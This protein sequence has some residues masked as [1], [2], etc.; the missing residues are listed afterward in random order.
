MPPYSTR[1]SPPMNNN[2][3]I[4]RSARQARRAL[5]HAEQS[6]HAAQACQHARHSTPFIAAQRIAAY[7]A[8]DG[9]LDPLPLVNH[10]IECNKEIYLPVLQPTTQNQ[11]WF[12]R[13]IPGEP[14]I[15]NRYAI[16]EPD[17]K[18]HPPIKAWSLDLVLLPLVAFDK[19][20][21]RVG[22]GGGYYDRTFAFM[23]KITAMPRPKLF[24]YAHDCQMTA[25]IF[26]NKWDVPLDGVITEKQ[27]Y[28]S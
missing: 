11:L 10:A 24:G 3:E 15:P 25:N 23:R 13:Y 26:L 27:I 19:K 20:G 14:L 6:Q 12:S 1:Q 18:Y 16:P 7:I 28:Y 4:R 8:T 9:E 17:I 5:T 2:A 21:S 22:M